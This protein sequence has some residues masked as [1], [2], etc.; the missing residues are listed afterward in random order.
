MSYKMLDQIEKTLV[1]VV[2]RVCG[3]RRLIGGLAAGCF[4]AGCLAL[5]LIPD[6]YA[7]G[8]DDRG[9]LTRLLI[10]HNDMRDI[11]N[12]D[13][14]EGKILEIKHDDGTVIRVN[15]DDI[16]G[17]ERKGM[18]GNDWY[19]WAQNPSGLTPDQ[20]KALEAWIADYEGKH[21]PPA[22][23]NGSGIIV[24]ASAPPPPPIVDYEKLRHDCEQARH[25]LIRA[26]LDFRLLKANYTGA[27]DEGAT[28]A[29]P[30]IKTQKALLQAF[31]QKRDGALKE[32][33]KNCGEM[34]RVYHNANF[35][36]PTLEQVPD[37]T[38]AA[39]ACVKARA[40]YAYATH[41]K[42]QKGDLDPVYVC[43]A[44]L[45]DTTKH[46]RT[47]VNTGS[48]PP[49][50]QADLYKQWRQGY[51]H[52]LDCSKKD[53][54]GQ[55]TSSGGNQDVVDPS[56]PPVPTVTASHPQEGGNQ[57]NDCIDAQNAVAHAQAEFD[58]AF[59]LLKDASI[60]HQD[61]QLILYSVDDAKDSVDAAKAEAQRI[62]NAPTKTTPPPPPTAVIQD[63]PPQSP[64]IHVP[65]HVN[66]PNAAPGQLDWPLP[67]V[68][69]DNG[70]GESVDIGDGPAPDPGHTGLHA[71][72]HSGSSGGGHS[73][74]S[75]GTMVSTG[76]SGSS[77]GI[78][79][80]QPSA[81][82]MVS[83]Y[84]AGHRFPD[85]HAA[86]H[87]AAEHRA[88]EHRAAEHH[89]AEHHFAGHG[90]GHGV[91][92]GH[93]AG[94]GGGHGGGGFGGFG[95]FSAH[96][97]VR[98]KHD[99]VLLGRLDNGLGFYRFSYN[100]SNKVYVGVMAQEVQSIKPEA[101]VRGRDGYLRV[102]YERLG[103]HLQTWDQWQASGQRIPATANS[104]R[105]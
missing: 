4:A 80:I 37:C 36:Q 97:D 77:G 40:Q 56:L 46:L 26:E 85:H 2:G 21:P 24:E 38:D 1:F 7:A 71:L 10:Y 93:G 53:P 84:F 31:Q 83:H 60:D 82:P 99:I 76:H 52:W 43:K 72:R 39:I 67:S 17:K 47:L 13:A 25:N 92:F 30:E 63:P 11:F 45:E 89:A 16:K 62:C 73:G 3:R 14:A 49:K 102:Y 91:G 27:V 94:Y 70:S 51:L 50:H 8:S 105:P 104:S 23:A 9:Q 28:D 103:L 98:L 15:L 48:S 57:S 88:A 66:L 19:E 96:S 44:D 59:S 34:E 68:G 6:A 20:K 69:G 78:V 90:F 79:T 58:K 61:L 42:F 32:D 35:T 5:L 101:V 29:D 75:G 54:S 87:H 95:G 12:N 100:G 55:N 41:S 33:A 22:S 74:S 81:S 18:D 64:H 86:E 65:E